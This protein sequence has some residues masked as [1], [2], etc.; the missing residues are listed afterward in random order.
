MNLENLSPERLWYYFA[1]LC[2]I[3]R[4]SKHE[5]QVVAFIED[6]AKQN[7]LAY[8]KDEVGNV[9]IRKGAS[10]GM[11]NKPVVVLQSHVDMV[12]QKNND[13]KHDFTKDPIKPVVENGWVRAD[14]TT[15]GADNGIGVAA[16]LS[17]LED[18]NIK[19]GPLEAL[20]TIDEETGMTGAFSLKE[21]FVKGRVLL[22]L[23]SEEDGVIC[24]GC[25]GGLDG[26]VQFHYI[27]ELVP[28]YADAFQLEIKGLVGGHSGVDIHKE[29]GNA[30]KILNRFLW[31]A[32]KSF[33]LRLSLIE[34]GSLR[35]A[36][37]REAR[38]VFTIDNGVV[39]DFKE[40]VNTERKIVIDEFI[41][42]E[43]DLQVVLSPTEQPFT[44]IQENVQHSLLNALYACPNGVIRM[45]SAMPG[46]VETS[47]NLAKIAMQNG[48]IEIQ[49]LLRSAIES[50]KNNVANMIDSVFTLAGADVS[51]D[52]EYPGWKPDPGSQILKTTVGVFKELNGTEPEVE[53]IHAGLECGIIGARYP[54]MD[55]VSFGPTITGAHSPD[56][57]VEIKSVEKFWS[58]LVNILMKV[59]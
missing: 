32:S 45:S 35:N 11:E 24:V 21:N 52:G 28:K 42:N 59:N 20:F 8:E 27:E 14:K 23:D 17:V 51:F 13:K 22:N 53:V 34:G 15:L 26:N 54:G 37:P 4:P 56:E 36:I 5:G 30:I 49:C 41:H 47:T 57:K 18:K 25:A 39:N 50:A 29:R 7:N 33:G 9:V 31:Y 2:K 48:V 46:V 1:Q 43:P 58:S 3:P 38:A 6:F 40:F 12:P 16:M 55:M 10:P 19:H 44:L